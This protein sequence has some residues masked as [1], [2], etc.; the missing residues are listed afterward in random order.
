LLIE[1]NPDSR[2]TLRLLLETWGHVVDTACDGA[3]GISKALNWM[4]EVAIVDIGLPVLDGYEV[5]RRLRAAFQEQLLLIAL[6]GFCQPQDR[7]EAIRS[8]FNVHM[9]KPAD[10]DLLCQILVQESLGPSECCLAAARPQ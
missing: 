4:P 1:D 2:A 9:I 10:L 5:A 7:S 6:T 3:E 8:G